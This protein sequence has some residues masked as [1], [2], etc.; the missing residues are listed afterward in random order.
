MRVASRRV[1]STVVRMQMRQMQGSA[2][3]SSSGEDFE[4]RIARR[5]VPSTVVTGPPL[6]GRNPPSNVT[7]GFLKGKS[8]NTRDFSLFIRNITFDTSNEDLFRI[9]SKYGKVL[10]AYIPFFPYS[11]TPRGYGFVRFRYEQEAK[12]AREVLNGR[13]I[14]GRIV[15]VRWAK[16]K[17]PPDRST[18]THHC[19][20]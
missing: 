9:F 10:D 13:R 3:A 19:Y 6:S 14:D 11:S 4:W 7:T 18:K 15:E 17:E 5:R 2:K 8:P 12:N 20:E 16:K 1:P